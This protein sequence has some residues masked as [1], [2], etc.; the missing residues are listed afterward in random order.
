MVESSGCGRHLN[1]VIIS[2]DPFTRGIRASD[3]EVS[4]SF[5]KKGHYDCN[6]MSKM[7]K[8][9]GHLSRKIYR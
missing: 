6:P 1:R 5:F 8:D 9:K 2:K 4:K 7:Q 3:H